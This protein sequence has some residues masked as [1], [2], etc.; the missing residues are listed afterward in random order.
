MNMANKYI[1]PVSNKIANLR[2]SGS[3]N[4]TCWN[5]ENQCAKNGFK[6]NLEFRLLNHPA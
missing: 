5:F 3:Q 6:L 1:Q 4:W 2:N